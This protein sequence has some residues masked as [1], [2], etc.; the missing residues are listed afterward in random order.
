MAHLK[1]AI[2]LRERADELKEQ[3]LCIHPVE[4]SSRAI[5]WN[6]VR[7]MLL[8]RPYSF[9]ML[10]IVRLPLDNIYGMPVVL[11]QTNVLRAARSSCLQDKTRKFLTWDR[12]LERGL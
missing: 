12:H 10:L 1:G 6:L 9:S 2:L 4:W 11:R 3:R 8:R 7:L 5:G